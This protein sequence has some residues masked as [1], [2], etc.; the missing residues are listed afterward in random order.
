MYYYTYEVRGNYWKCTI[1][2]QYEAYVSNCTITAALRSWYILAFIDIGILA[3]TDIGI[4]RY[5]CIIHTYSNNY[6]YGA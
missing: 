4:G 3:F 2:F 1:H 6:W 5:T